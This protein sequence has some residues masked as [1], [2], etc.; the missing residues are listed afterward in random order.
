MTKVNKKI[1][2]KN[3]KTDSKGRTKSEVRIFIF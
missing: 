3:K 2:P 1:S